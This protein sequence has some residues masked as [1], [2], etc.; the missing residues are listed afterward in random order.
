MPIRM[1]SAATES[2]VDKRDQTCPEPGFGQA[3]HPGVIQ[4][5][6]I[7][8]IPVATEADGL[9]IR[10]HADLEIGSATLAAVRR[11]L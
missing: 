2:K 10:G 1:R 8:R 7:R 9:L 3:C 5:K 6:P 4:V 11:W